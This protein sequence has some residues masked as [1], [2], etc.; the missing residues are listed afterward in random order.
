MQPTK[1]EGWGTVSTRMW[2]LGKSV[3][4]KW[5]EIDPALQVMGFTELNVANMRKATFD[6]IATAIRRGYVLK[7]GPEREMLRMILTHSPSP[8]SIGYVGR[9][10]MTVFFPPTTPV[11]QIVQE[12]ETMHELVDSSKKLPFQQETT[13]TG[14]KKLSCRMHV[15][16]GKGEGPPPA[17]FARARKLVDSYLEEALSHRQPTLDWFAS[18]PLLRLP[19]ASHTRDG[20][21]RGK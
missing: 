16:R 13:T 17:M 19:F 14:E 6:Y 4:W 21:W 3:S 15:H 7:D 9:T 11:Y 20:E 8:I 1:P 18:K 12:M 5:R 2:T 10:R